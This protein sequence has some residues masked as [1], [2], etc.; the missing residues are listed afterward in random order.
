VVR[1]V[2]SLGRRFGGRGPVIRAAHRAAESDESD[3]SAALRLS[4]VVAGARRDARA[5]LKYFA[6]QRDEFERDRAYRLLEAAV[7]GQPVL[8]IREER[9]ELFG[10]EETLGR[11]PLADAFAV[12]AGC[13][14]ELRELA[15]EAAASAGSEPTA[16][17][18]KQ[19]SGER[20]RVSSMVLDEVDG[21]GG[22]CG[23]GLARSIVAQYLQILE[24]SDDSD[25]ALAYF[26]LPRKRVVLISRFDAR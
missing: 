2:D 8:P 6:D 20:R 5:A 18:A 19:Q 12:L 16:V 15:A 21:G 14:P 10:E 7:K 13:K 11:M 26:A 9:R 23:S 3:E 1:F 22:V 4:S 25:P 24:G 17:Q